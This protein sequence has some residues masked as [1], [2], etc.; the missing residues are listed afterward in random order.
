MSEYGIKLNPPRILSG[1][2]PRR[3]RGMMLVEALCALAIGAT[4][5][6]AMGAGFFTFLDSWQT[7][8]NH[9]DAVKATRLAVL[10]ICSDI[11]QA[12]D[13]QV[14][15]TGVTPQ[16][17]T[18]VLSL[19]TTAGTQVTDVF[20][21]SGTQLRYYRQLS[22]PLSG[23]LSSQP[24]SA[25]NP[26]GYTV[27]AHNV[28]AA[29]FTPQTDPVTGKLTN[30]EISMKVT[31]NNRFT[32]TLTESAVVRHNRVMAEKVNPTYGAPPF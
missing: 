15:Y 9:A 8:V 10:K 3:Q 26:T 11:R 19:T 32:F 24:I 5:M 13:G 21:L 31:L 6:V 14:G 27:L 30:V 25:S 4:L 23:N 18:L 20:S 7:N 17:G 12:D 1:S 29:T 28:S 22:S 16:S 2:C